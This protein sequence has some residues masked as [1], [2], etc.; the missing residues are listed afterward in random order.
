[1]KV[2]LLTGKLA[3]PQIKKLAEKHKAEVHVFN[4][5]VAAFITPRMIFKELK[6]KAG[7]YDLIV[8]P[9]VIA[10]DLEEVSK[11]LGTPVVKGSKDYSTLDILLE[12][13]SSLKLSHTTPADDLLREFMKQRAEKEFAYLEKHREELLKKEHNFLIG[14]IAVGR[15]FPPRVVAE[16]VG[17]E[18]LNRE[19]ILERAEYYLKSGASIVDLGFG[20]SNPEK[21]EEAVSLLKDRDITTSIDTMDIKNIEAGIEAGVDLILSFGREQIEALP[22]VKTPAVIVPMAEDKLPEKAEDRVKLLEENIK[23]A[24]EHGFSKVIADAVLNHPNYGLAESIAAYRL[25]AKRNPSVPMLF[26]AGNV[27]E[28][29]DADSPGI[30]AI[31]A[32]IASELGAELL[33]TTEA[34]SKTKGSVVELS[35]AAKLAFLARKHRSAPKDLGIDLL[36][37]KEKHIFREPLPEFKA[38]IVEAKEDSTYIEDRKG[39]FKIYVA[40]SIYAVHYSGEEPDVVIK[41]KNASEISKTICRLGL[42]SEPSHGLYLGRELQ[43][44][45]FALKYNK[46]YIQD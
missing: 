44:A 6:D 36:I 23:L 22:G 35:K 12:N 5:D 27:T 26:G 9:G 11:K 31:L 20:E 18:K 3:A 40:D 16:I 4:T 8:A 1:M 13:L 25:F 46:S 17:V 28:L 43:K 32:V 30:N 15:D 39:Y 7:E 14:R 38:E 41:G 29:I 33:F 34:S 37:L 21:V 24:K 2:L 10:G 42:I 19:E 45:E